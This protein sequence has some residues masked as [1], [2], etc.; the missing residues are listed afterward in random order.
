MYKIKFESI[1]ED[2]NIK[3]G[4]NLRMF[5]TNILMY[6]IKTNLSKILFSKKEFVIINN[7]ADTLNIHHEDNIVIKLSINGGS[8]IDI[9]KLVT[10]KN[11]YGSAIIKRFFKSYYRNI[12]DFIIN[13]RYMLAESYYNNLISSEDDVIITNAYNDKLKYHNGSFT[14][15][16]KDNAHSVIVQR[17]EDKD[18]IIKFLIFSNEINHIEL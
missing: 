16:S 3:Y 11:K 1:K 17:L 12:Y 6:I 4:N 2:L 5:N 13:H 14:L 18:T 15:E 8:Y 7:K 10:S 9:T